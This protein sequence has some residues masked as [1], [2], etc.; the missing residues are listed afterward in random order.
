VTDHV[1]VRVGQLWRR[2]RDGKPFIPAHHVD[3]TWFN[4]A[5]V[6]RTAG[7]LR[8]KYVLISTDDDAAPR[9]E[10]RTIDPS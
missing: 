1:R 7:E 10:Q 4:K 5:G 6:K 3:N 8:D 2:R 9:G